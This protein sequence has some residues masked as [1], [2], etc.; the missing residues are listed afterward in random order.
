MSG[1][2]ALLSEYVQK[3]SEQAF[4][5][6]VTAYI[7][8]VFST[9]LRLVAGDRP[10]AEDVTQ[11]VFAD[12]ARK[13]PALPKEVRLGGWLH[14]HTCF[15]ARKT[16]RRERRR[17]AREQQAVRLQSIE[18]YTEANLA[19]LAIVMDEAIND[20][21]ESDRHAITLRFFED[22]DFRSI[23]ELL[24]SSEDAA[25]M[26]V[27]RAIQKMGAQLKRRG[28]VV[29]VSGL[30]FVLGAGLS[31]A[32]PASLAAKLSHAAFLNALASPGLFSFFRKI[33]YPRLLI[34]TTAAILL[35][36]LILMLI[37]A[38][39]SKLVRDTSAT[40][41]TPAEFAD[42]S[43]EARANDDP[44]MLPAISREES[45]APPPQP[46]PA[47]MRPAESTPPAVVVTP[48]SPPPGAPPPAAALPQPV[49]T[50][51]PSNPG[52]VNPPAA[53]PVF[54]T[55]PR[56]QNVV[57]WRQPAFYPAYPADARPSPAAGPSSTNAA[58][59]RTLPRLNPSSQ[60]WSAVTAVAAPKSEAAPRSAPANTPATPP[61]PPR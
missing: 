60:P 34:G 20:L 41:M 43:F 57:P 5:A 3:G 26:R 23:G 36:G 13:A 24:G 30:G 52:P 33:L 1:N 28:I 40:T 4:R 27:S 54:A 58:R 2:H 46:V 53:G 56:I 42:V 59:A 55:V 44:A 48:P 47:V 32:A 11:T 14:R 21:A 18:D 22:L 8:F 12:L 37:P 10:L 29:S 15:V 35:I 61:P 9:A 7:D 6:L 49:P 39:H 16:L 50:P 31:A 19:Q 51:K 17:V 45:P 38:R 25:R